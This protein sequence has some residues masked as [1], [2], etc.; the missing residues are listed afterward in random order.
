MN[1]NGEQLIE[2]IC[3][4]IKDRNRLCYDSTIISELRKL[5]HIELNE[6]ITFGDVGKWIRE[7]NNGL[8]VN[9][10]NY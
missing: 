2:I 7:R 1:K 4:R 10:S 3:R 6:A 9:E 8:K 5:T